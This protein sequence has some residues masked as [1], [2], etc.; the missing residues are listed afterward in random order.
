MAEEKKKTTQKSAPKSEAVEEVKVE[1]RFCTQCGKELKEGEVCDCTAN[2]TVVSTAS[3]INGDT[4]VNTCKDIWNTIINVFKKPATTISE[5]ANSSGSNK[6]IILTIILAISF[7]LYLMA[8]VSSMAKSAVDAS[9]SLWGLSVEVDVPYLQVF[10]YG[11]LIYAVMVILPAVAALVVA[12]IAK[13]ANFTFKKAFKLYVISNAPQ[14]FA[15][16]G[17]AIILLLNVSLLNVLGTIATL[18]IGVF[19]FFNFILG[20]NRETKMKDDARSYAVTGLISFWVVMIV[21][22]IIILGA[23]VYSSIVGDTTSGLDNYSEYFNW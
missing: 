22:L 8:I 14:V 13:N 16:L 2:E 9:T 10:I 12:K 7:A 21:V 6:S 11:I 5:E 23:T 20:F 17:M 4:I 1:K 15:Y 18:I 19:C 3:T